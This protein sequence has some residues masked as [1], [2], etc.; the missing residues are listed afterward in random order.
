MFA[1]HPLALMRY[2][3]MRTESLIRDAAH[4]RLLDALR[5]STRRG[6]ARPSSPDASPARDAA[7]SWSERSQPPAPAL[8]P[9]AGD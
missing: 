5:G 8:E 4:Q 2:R 6:N 7:A 3:E 9:A 1:N